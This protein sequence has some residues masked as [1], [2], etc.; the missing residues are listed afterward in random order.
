VGATVAGVIALLALVAGV[1][2]CHRR[3]HRH[4]T[5]LEIEEGQ[6]I[7]PYDLEALSL[8][9][10]SRMKA[11]MHVHKKDSKHTALCIRCD[12]YPQ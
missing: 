8:A 3:R 4:I 7:T 6:K 10:V 2:F 12:L 5:V 9:L 1:I 11:P